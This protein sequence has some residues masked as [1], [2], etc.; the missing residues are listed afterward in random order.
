M[1]VLYLLA[2]LY[3]MPPEMV[4]RI[5]VPMMRKEAA[6]PRGLGRLLEEERWAL[7]P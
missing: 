5:I 2:P 7:L 3:L 4:F 6:L 1:A